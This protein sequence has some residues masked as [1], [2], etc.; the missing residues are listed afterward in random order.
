MELFIF[1][2]LLAS[3]LL[4]AYWNLILKSAP[5]K[6]VAV[7][8]IF[9][10]S[11]P[12][13]LIGLAYGGVPKFEFLPIILLSSI[14][15]TCYNVSLFKAYEIGQLSSI[16][17]VARGTA[18]LFI[19]AISYAFFGSKI[20]NDMAIGVTF[21]CSGL[22]AYGLL[23]LRRNCSNLTELKLALLNG[24]FIAL[25]S[26]NDAFGTRMTGNAL[27]FLGMMALFNRIFLFI[28]LYV[29]EKNFLPR[30]ISGFER[31]F[32]LGGIISFICYVIVLVAY[33]HLPV[34]V[35]STIR[36]TSVIFAVALGVIV[37]REKFVWDKFG[38]VALVLVG[39]FILAP[40]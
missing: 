8:S 30:L 26:L 18:P 28:Y 11:L 21:I 14:L 27:S 25:Y 19:F 40:K 34:A 38:L 20:S 2:L 23:Q 4:H 36:E 37:L 16:Y 29:F 35:V 17:P 6:A 31:R 10:T 24:L 15:H 9:F 33:M 22:I 3:A 13:A 12:F 7:M 5:D 39:L 32:I 1:I